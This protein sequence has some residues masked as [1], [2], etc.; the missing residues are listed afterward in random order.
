VLV[1]V[2]LTE[3][4]VALNDEL[5]AAAGR[6][7]ATMPAARLACLNVVKLNR[8]ALDSTLDAEGHNKHIDR[9]VAL[10]HWAEPLRLVEGEH[11][12]VHVMDAVNPASAILDFSNENHVSHILIGARQ[13]SLKRSLLG[14]VSA[15][16]VAD[17][18]C[19]VTVVRPPGAGAA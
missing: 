15:E 7:L 13:N 17:A 19:T 12:T 2:D 14:G 5:R 18:A 6:L 1:A 10:K 16:V 11:L 8:I 9:L 3:G 4:T